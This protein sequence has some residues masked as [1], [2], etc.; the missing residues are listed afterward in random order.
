MHNIE[1]WDIDSIIK[2]NESQ[3]DTWAINL[4]ERS[5]EIPNASAYFPPGWIQPTGNFKWR[6]IGVSTPTFSTASGQI[7]HLVKMNRIPMTDLLLDSN[8]NIDPSYVGK[9]L[10]YFVVE[11]VVDGAC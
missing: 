10:H 8:N 4:N 3:D 6:P 5:I 7:Y 2:S 1:N 11:N 9:Y